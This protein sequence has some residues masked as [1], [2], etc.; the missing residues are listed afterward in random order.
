MHVY[1]MLFARAYKRGGGGAAS[2]RRR[3]VGKGRGD[4]SLEGARGEALCSHE[5]RS[6]AGRARRRSG[7]PRGE[8]ARQVA[9]PALLVSGDVSWPIGGSSLVVVIAVILV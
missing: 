3:C 1:R 9:Y 8:R 7:V 5:G 4:G 2:G 6:G